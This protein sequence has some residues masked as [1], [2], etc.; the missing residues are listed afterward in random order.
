MRLET[1]AKWKK[2]SMTNEIRVNNDIMI[3][4][5][6]HLRLGLPSGLLPSGFS[7]NLY[8]ALFSLIRATCPAHLI[9]LTLSILITLK[10]ID[11]INLLGS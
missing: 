7:T 3:H 11:S 5:S 10:P 9:F 4:T 2:I 6:V 8:A 1:L